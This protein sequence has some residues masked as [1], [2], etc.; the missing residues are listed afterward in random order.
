MLEALI[1]VN[2]Y[3]DPISLKR[4]MNSLPLHAQIFAEYNDSVS[5]TE[6]IYLRFM[7]CETT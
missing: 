5:C 1:S 4:V 3:Q 6:F 2:I 7:G